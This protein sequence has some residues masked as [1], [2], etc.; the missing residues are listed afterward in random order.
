MAHFGTRL[1]IERADRTP[2]YRKINKHFLEKK[3]KK[4]F[5]TIALAVVTVFGAT[6]ANAGIIVGDKPGII[7]GDKPEPCRDG[8]IV[9]DRPG[10][11]ISDLPGIIVGDAPGIIISDIYG[12]IV[13]DSKCDGGKGTNGIIVGD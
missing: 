12:I 5:T 8:I 7:V 9:G 4:A 2:R 6:F 10:I 1:V 13:G 3:M 11:I